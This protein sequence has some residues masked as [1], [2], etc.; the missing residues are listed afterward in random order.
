LTGTDKTDK[1]KPLIKEVEMKILRIAF[2]LVIVSLV[3]IEAQDKKKPKPP[4][5]EQKVFVSRA[6]K[7][8]LIPL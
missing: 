5:V 7:H 8:G 4:Q 2:I 3:L 1:K 6:T